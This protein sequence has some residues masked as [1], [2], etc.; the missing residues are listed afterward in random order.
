MK[1]FRRGDT[2]QRSNAADHEANHTKSNLNC[3][4]IGLVVKHAM[5][6]S[7]G[8]AAWIIDSGATRYKKNYVLQ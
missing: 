8:K 3:E 7:S 2:K 4:S 5:L 1:K 6:T